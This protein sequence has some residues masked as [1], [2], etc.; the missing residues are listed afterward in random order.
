MPSSVRALRSGGLLFIVVLF[1]L[2][3]LKWNR[4]DG[5]K[6]EALSFLAGDQRLLVFAPHPDDDLVGAGPALL[7]FRGQKTV[8]VVTPGDGFRVS[9]A[10]EAG[11]THP[12]ADDYAKYALRRVKEQLKGLSALLGKS[13]VQIVHL[14]FPD[15]GLEPMLE[16]EG[17]F[18]SPYTHRT[19]RTDAHQKETHLPNEGESLV[20]ALETVI[21][22]VHPTLILAP[23]PSD[24]HP[25]HR[26]LGGLVDLA[27]A[28]LHAQA[29]R[30]STPRLLFYLVHRGDWPAPKGLHD[31]LALNPPAT[32]KAMD[33][34]WWRFDLS[35]AE[36]GRLLRAVRAHRTQMTFLRPI[37]T[38]F[39]RSNGLLAEI[40]DHALAPGQTISLKE[41]IRDTLTRYS[42]PSRDLVEVQVRRSQD[43]HTLALRAKTVA[44]PHGKGTVYVF[45][46]WSLEGQA[47]QRQ[48]VT[49]PRPQAVVKVGDG[50]PVM[51]RVTL[52]RG[53][54][55]IDQSALRVLLAVPS[56]S[57]KSPFALPGPARG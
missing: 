35:P 18:Q 4:P 26:A 8:V 57:V 9:V 1:V 37:L 27:V 20:G 11:V 38:A 15:K 6:P 41:P 48:T 23:H 19:E 17:L 50:G 34:R 46:L 12:K 13:P 49:T 29:P 16:R 2:Y 14:G 30:A 22:K 45:R 47:L 3:N 56:L 5:P 55:R 21:Q 51:V 54:Q 28:D 42:D 53:K 24:S 31:Q 39:I 7:R 25:D 33:S 43:G 52:F 44:P 36:R 10:W 32:M 40:P